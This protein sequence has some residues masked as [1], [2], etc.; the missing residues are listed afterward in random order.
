MLRTF[1]LELPS[2]PPAEYGANR[3]RGAAWGR[4]YRISHG[5]RGAADEIIA[6]ARAQ[7]WQGEPFLHATVFVT[8]FLPDRRKRDAG[9]LQ[10]RIKPWLDALTP[11]GVGVIADD[12]LATIGWPIY[13]HLY[14]PR[15]P[16]TVIRIDEVEEK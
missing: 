8:F 3:A 14:S 11:K 13:G 10:E 12:D 4:Q 15:Q 16:K 5:K 9:M 1:C 7:G 2:L 6:A